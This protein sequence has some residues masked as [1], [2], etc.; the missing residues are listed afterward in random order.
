MPSVVAFSDLSVQVHQTSFVEHGMK[1]KI[2]EY[3]NA[4]IDLPVQKQ[5]TKPR[6]EV[7]TVSV[8]DECK[9]NKSKFDDAALQYGEYKSIITLNVETSPKSKY[10]C[11]ICNKIMIQRSL[12]TVNKHI[13]SKTHLNKIERYIRRKEKDAKK[14]KF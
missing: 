11:N 12:D 5:K 3:E 7:K 9:I 2:E 14:L 13:I 6:R 4:K 10:K 1:I 8:I